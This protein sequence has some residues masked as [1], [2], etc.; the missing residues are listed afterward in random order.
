MNFKKFIV[1]SALMPLC[2]GRAATLTDTTVVIEKPDKVIISETAHDVSVKVEGRKNNAAFRYTYSTALGQDNTYAVTETDDAGG[3]VFPFQK[4]NSGGSFPGFVLGFSNAINSEPE[5]TTHFGSGV[6]IGFYPIEYRGPKL[7]NHWNVNLNFGFLWRNYRMTDGNRF[8]KTDNKVIVTSYPDGSDIRFS[9]IKTFSL[10]VPISLTW[11]AKLPHYRLNACFGP[12]IS[13][14]TYASIKT[15]YKLDGKKH[16][17]VDK[18]IH[19]VPVSVDLFGGFGC[20]DIGVYV[21]W[22]PFHVLQTGSAPRF[23]C[24]SCGIT[25]DL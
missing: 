10:Q 21:R 12:I 7:G 18:N 16:K 6:E 13:W 22:S 24:L 17:E 19:Q 2:G 4:S 8:A 14:N 5:I 20:N 25:F 1:L 11:Q 9:R 23:D 15:R 3:L